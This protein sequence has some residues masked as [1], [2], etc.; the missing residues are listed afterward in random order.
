M[1]PNQNCSGSQTF[2][3][4]GH[5]L[6]LLKVILSYATSCTVDLS[7]RVL[8]NLPR[9]RGKSPMKNQIIYTPHTNTLHTLTTRSTNTPYMYIILTTRSTRAL[10]SGQP[11]L[12]AGYTYAMVRG[13]KNSRTIGHLFRGRGGGGGDTSSTFVDL[14][15]LPSSAN[16]GLKRCTQS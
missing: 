5:E 13:R 3:Y 8:A 2:S 14:D 4:P 9:D 6:Y 16:S 15:L 10:L 11:Y 7:Q 1:L 12:N